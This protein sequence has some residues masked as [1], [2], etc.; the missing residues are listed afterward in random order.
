M[1]KQRQREAAKAEK[2]AA[3]VAVAAAKGQA[4]AAKAF[5]SRTR[6]KRSHEEI[7]V[8]VRCF[9]RG[10][11]RHVHAGRSVHGGIVAADESALCERLLPGLPRCID[12]SLVVHWVTGGC[13]DG[14]CDTHV[15]VKR[16]L[17]WQMSK[18]D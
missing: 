16:D 5:E 10:P 1:E 7:T 14:C 3:K 9:A 17:S 4:K 12:C 2:A 13:R 8:V 15:L 11:G 6:G 18:A